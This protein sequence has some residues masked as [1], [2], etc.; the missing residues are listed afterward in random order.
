MIPAAL[1]L[2]TGHALRGQGLSTE[3]MDSEW[4][5]YDVGL[6]DLGLMVEGEKNT[7]AQ[8]GPRA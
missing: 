1:E 6:A 2:F 7:A 3:P 8:R 5:Y 4:K